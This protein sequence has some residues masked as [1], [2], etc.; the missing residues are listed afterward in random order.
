MRNRLQSAKKQ[1][2]NRNQKV[3]CNPCTGSVPDIHPLDNQYFSSRDA[4][5]LPLVQSWLP[6]GCKKSTSRLD[7]HLRSHTKLTKVAQRDALQAC[8]RKKKIEDLASLRASNPEEPMVS[9]LDLDEAQDV[10][11]VPTALEEE[12]DKTDQQCVLQNF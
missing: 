5:G 6:S 9:T 10:W 12:C 2:A 1:T 4:F 8:K 11:D 7:R 3:I